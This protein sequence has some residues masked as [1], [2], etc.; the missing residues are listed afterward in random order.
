VLAA[1]LQYR[2]PL[3]W[4]E[5]GLGT[6]PLFIQNINAAA[7][8]DFGMTSSW[9]ETA[10][11]ELQTANSGQSRAR[12]GIGA[13]LRTDFILAH[14]LPANLHVGFGFGLNPFWSYQLYFGLSSSMLEGIL[15]SS[16]VNRQSSIPVRH[17]PENH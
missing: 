11:C 13:E 1:G 16:L 14:L 3:W 17:L 15:Y 10:N 9:P 4:I 8:S 5:R 7:F 12:I 2:T 6:G